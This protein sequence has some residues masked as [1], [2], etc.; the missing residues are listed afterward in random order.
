[1]PRVSIGIGIRASIGIDCS[2][3]K[4]VKVLRQSFYDLIFSKSSDGFG[5][6]LVRL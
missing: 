6:Y 4:I 2:F 1:M 3:N 5:S